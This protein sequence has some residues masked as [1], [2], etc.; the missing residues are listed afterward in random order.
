MTHVTKQ[1]ASSHKTITPTINNSHFHRLTQTLPSPYH[2]SR[3]PEEKQRVLSRRKLSSQPR[4][5]PCTVENHDDA[6]GL[7]QGPQGSVSSDSLCVA[8]GADS[9]R[10]NKRFHVHCRQ[11]FVFSLLLPPPFKYILSALM[12]GW[13][14]SVR[15]T[16]IAVAWRQ[17]K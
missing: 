6:A 3:L 17:T 10:Q 2:G 5:Y 1:P 15:S 16:S 12:F 7:P 9:S 8:C 13:E 14:A 4:R 11:L